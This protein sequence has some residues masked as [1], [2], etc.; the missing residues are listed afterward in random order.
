MN[1]S[2]E[3][4]GAAMTGNITPDMMNSMAG[5][6]GLFFWWL[7]M[8]RMIVCL[9]IMVFMI[10]S[11]RRIFKKAGLPGRWSLIPVYNRVLMFKL[12]GMSG[13]RALS[14]LFPPLFAIAM[15]INYF[16]IA[17]NFWKHWAFGLGMILVKIV[18]IPILAFDDSKYLSKKAIIKPIAKPVIKAVVKPAAKVA[19]PAAKPVAKAPV[20]KA[21][22]KKAPAKK[23]VKKV[24]TLTKKK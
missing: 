12:G 16:N 13:R 18:F 8:V 11:R 7:A 2:F 21:P 19:K 15:I 24:K 3:L 10:I 23:V 14:I 22:A 4:E 5:A 17:K 20:K 9:A 1:F 6:F